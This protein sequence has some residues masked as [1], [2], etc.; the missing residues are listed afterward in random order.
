MM[1]FARTTFLLF[2]THVG[3]V[4]FSRRAIVCIALALLPAL[5]AAAVA[6]FSRRIDQVQIAVHLGGL[7]LLQI[8]VPILALIA[9]SA[10]VA[11]EVEDRTITY[12]FSR[13]IPR[14]SL[15]FG[16]W[17]ATLLFL[18]T[19][20]FVGTWL[21]VLAASTSKVAGAQLDSSITR[22]L[23]EAVL[24]GAAV[25]SSLFAVAGIVFKSPILVGLGYTF[26]IEGF[27][28]NLPG[29]NQSLTI[30]YYLRC[31]LLDRGGDPWKI[32]GLALDKPEAVANVLT[33]LACILIVTLGFGA[34]RITRREFVLTP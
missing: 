33:T 29:G 3:R 6:H 9:G 7:L 8:I 32:E 2:T 4:F 17:W 23:F 5:I 14:A 13:P 34:W 25:Y 22:A 18:G 11:E 19:I 1:L 31:W 30:Q 21:F 15:L 27:L 10:V 16:R 28:A 20:L 12:L 24:L 26:A